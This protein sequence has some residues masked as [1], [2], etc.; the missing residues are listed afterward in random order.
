MVMSL[1]IAKPV[2]VNL[3]FLAREYIN[4]IIEQSPATFDRT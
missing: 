4:L 3:R 1:R 2:A